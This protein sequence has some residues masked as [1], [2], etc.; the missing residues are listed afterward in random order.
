MG[1]KFV[2]LPD[3]IQVSNYSL[4]VVGLPK[5]TP[6]SIGALEQELDKVDL[7]DRTTVSGGRT[8]AGEFEMKIPLHHTQ[9]IAAMKTWF[10]EAQ[11]PQSPTYKKTGTLIVESGSKINRS[12]ITLIGLWVSKKAI[13][14]L[15]MN[16]DGDMAEA[17]FTMAY[18][19]LLG[20]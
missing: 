20:L 5:L 6:T 18:D 11:D 14:D 16:N 2:I 9:E 3:P 19:D 12:V 13:P 7:P 8:K 1:Q 17:T 15:E 10:A 4:Q